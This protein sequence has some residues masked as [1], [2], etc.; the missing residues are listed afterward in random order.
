SKVHAIEAAYESRHLAR[1]TGITGKVY[2]QSV[3]E[4]QD[5][6]VRQSEVGIDAVRGQIRS[7]GVCDQSCGRF[8]RMVGG[9]SGNLHTRTC[10]THSQRTL[11]SDSQASCTRRG[12]W[13]SH[14]IRQPGSGTPSNVRLKDCRDFRAD[15]CGKIS[16][17]DDCGIFC[18]CNL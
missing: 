11:G 4:S 7:L 2:L 17:R 1:K 6:P 18:T 8:I 15:E 3:R 9:N 13:K 12:A 16:A 10:R 14:F 5:E